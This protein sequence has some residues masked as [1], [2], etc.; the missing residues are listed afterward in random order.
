MKPIATDIYTFSELITNGYTYVDKTDRYLQLI[1]G[2]IGKQFFLARPRRFG[3]SLTV[4]T[5]QAIFEGR[6]SLFTGLAIESAW[7]WTK[8]WPVLRLDMGSCQASSVEEFWDKLGDLLISESDR[9]EI[10]L[11]GKSPSSQFRFFIEDLARRNRNEI[12]VAAKARGEPLPSDVQGQMVL[13]VDEYDKPILGHLGKTDVGE[14]RDALKD[15][16]SVIKTCESCQR[17][18]FI[19]GVSKFSKVSIFSDLNNLVDLTMDARTATMFGYT[20]DEVKKYF[21]EH[22]AALGAANGLAPDEAFDKVIAM[23]NGYCFHHAAE[24]VV[25]PVSLGR[26]FC[27][28]EFKSYWYETGTPTFLVELLKK[29][30]IDISNLEILESQLGSYEPQAPQ[31]VPLLFQTGYLTIKDFVSDDDGNRFYRLGFP[32]NEVEK[33]FS[34]TLTMAYTGVDDI[35]FGRVQVEGRRALANHDLKKFFELLG[36]LFAN[37]PYDL[38]DRQNEQTWQAIFVVVLRFLGIKVIPESRTNRGRI[39]AVVEFAHEIY[40]IE[41]KLNKTAADAL[42]QIKEKR[43]HEKYLASGKRITLVGIN[44]SSESR[45]IDDWKSEVVA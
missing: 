45:T 10:P 13:L 36:I 4:S 28:C 24:R 21:G 29:R 40:V 25:N 39:D 43:Y 37:L 1:A 8:T 34:E 9:L 35:A 27:D 41:V 17:F 26:C 42:T 12:L 23:Y 18:T 14:I 5:L 15:F 6:R 22:L 20:H 38:T 19:T 16:Y 30:P 7:D 11:R 33:A 3:K 2:K 44:F 31:V 32:N